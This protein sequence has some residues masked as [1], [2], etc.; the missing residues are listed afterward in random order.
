MSID[1]VTEGLAN[2]MVSEWGARHEEE[3]KSPSPS[4]LGD[5]SKSSLPKHTAAYLVSEYDHDSV[6]SVATMLVH[7]LRKDL[8]P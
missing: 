3:E 6:E 7:G 8:D 2:F 5:L 1:Q 4:K